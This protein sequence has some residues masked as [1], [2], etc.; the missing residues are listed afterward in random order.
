MTTAKERVSRA[1]RE[2]RGEG[3]ALTVEDELLCAEIDRLTAYCDRLNTSVVSLSLGRTR[4]PFDPFALVDKAIRARGEA[5]KKGAGEPELEIQARAHGG[6]V[7]VTA[8]G[9]TA[10]GRN[11]RDALSTLADGLAYQRI[12][13]PWGDGSD[14][15][16]KPAGWGPAKPSDVGDPMTNLCP[17]CLRSTLTP[18]GNPATAGR[19][20]SCEADLGR[21][22]VLAIRAAQRRAEKALAD[23]CGCRSGRVRQ[24]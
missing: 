11:L 22:N 21:V 8:L 17:I 1:Q 5:E 14:P 2:I 15:K 9:L 3:A 13:P 24:G 6:M 4:D 10:N 12:D 18:A 16:P 23:R 19:C 7:S 20:T